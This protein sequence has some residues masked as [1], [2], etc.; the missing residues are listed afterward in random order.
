M[1]RSVH[2]S[3]S[4]DGLRGA[5]EE[6]LERAGAELV[7]EPE[8]AEVTIQIDSPES[9][10]IAIVPLGSSSPGSGIVIELSDVII[11]NGG[12]K[13]G[14]GVI[15]DWIEKIMS[16][17]KPDSEPNI[18]FWVNVR[19]VVDAISTICLNGKEKIPNGNYTMCGRRAWEMADVTDEIRVLWERYNNSINHSHTIE[20]LSKVPSPV[21]GL[22]SRIE[23][24][25]DL[26]KIH[27]AL[28]MAGGDGWHPLVPMRVSLM[29][30]IASAK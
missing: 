22:H 7:D 21:R 30:M 2:V 17:K 20:S 19:D 26:T 15:T 24:R 28:V 29:E 13:W 23:E 16:G 6:R 1:P 10:D 5:L 14:N 4:S 18:R 3:G 25:P 9:S 27:E 8:K 12:K 11:P